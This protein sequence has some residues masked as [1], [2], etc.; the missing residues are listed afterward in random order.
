M[1]VCREWTN[2]IHF[3][4]E[5]HVTW[6]QTCISRPEVA[7]FAKKV[8]KHY[9]STFSLFPSLA[10]F[11]F[12]WHHPRNGFLGDHIEKFMS[13][14]TQVKHSFCVSFFIPYPGFL[15]CSCLLS[16]SILAHRQKTHKHTV[17]ACNTHKHN[18]H[19]H[20]ELLLTKNYHFM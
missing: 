19:K 2:K 20:F 4:F 8:L 13:A 15:F 6:I 18:I 7:N 12:F 10:L 9:H 11:F 3:S 17:I 16:F 5:Q 1:L 14:V